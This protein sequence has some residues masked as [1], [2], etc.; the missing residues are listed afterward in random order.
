MIELNNVSKVFAD[1]LVID[2]VNLNIKQGEIFGLIGLS[3][4]GKSTLLRIIN[5]LET[6]SSG[7]VIITEG[8]KFGFVF[9]NF[10]LVNSLTV[11]QNIKLALINSNLDDQ[12][13]SAKVL[14]V[15]KLVGLEAFA[16]VLPSKLS[17]GQKQRVGIARALVAD[18]DVLLCDE[19]TSA[20]DPFTAGE[21]INLLGELNLK[22]G[23][24][25]IFV[26]H[27]LEIVRDFCDR[28]A[29][30]DHGKICEVGNTI[31]VFSKPKSKVSLK[32]LSNVLGFD[33]YLSEPN[34]GMI[35]C[36]SR[37]QINQCIKYITNNDVELLA[38]YQHHTKQGIFAHIFVGQ[39]EDIEQFEV[40][41]IYGL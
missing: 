33:T 28:I 37:E 35:T 17:G 12:T 20:L 19:A 1:N 27:Q 9:Q 40:R 7:E 5:Q 41:S 39:T 10:N 16:K 25:I 30:I 24:T 8:T 26:S 14:E 31:D 11:E 18:V 13:Q 34:A 23:L 32:L 29:I 2:N 3:G 6:K 21:I 4:A 38:T 15:L 36:Y 22:L